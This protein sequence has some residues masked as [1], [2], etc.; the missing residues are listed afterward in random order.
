MTAA[1]NALGLEYQPLAPPQLDDPFPL[2]A[3][4][5]RE[6]PVTFAPGFHLWLVSRYQDVMTVLKDTRRF[7]SRDILRPP[8]DLPKELVELLTASGY[9][10]DY[11]LL[12]DDP[13]AH[14]RIRALV[15]KAFSPP[16]VS[17][18]EP[19]I[20]AIARGHLDAL[21]RNGTRADLISNLAWALPMDVITELLGVPHADRNQIREWTE[22]EKLIFVPQIPPDALRRAVEGVAAFRR[23]LRALVE[24]RQKN[25]REDILSTLISAR[26]DGENPL[27]TLEL[28][29]LASVLV[30]AGNETTTNLIGT[31]LLHL[32]RKPAL[33]E[34]LRANPAAIPNTIEEALRF[35]AP[36]VGMMRTATEPVQLGGA[37]IP[38]GARLLLLFASANRDETV[39]TDAERFD[40]HR[41]NASRHLG[42]G[43][44]THYCVGAPLA[45]L[46]ARV[47][48]GLLIEHLPNPRLAA[49]ETISYLPNLIHRGPGRLMVEWDAP[50]AL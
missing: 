4:L 7:S 13:P 22:H 15:G 28:M 30:F 34:E 18:M 17:A 20:R 46:E 38:A 36:V 29:N 11:P 5:R 14:T 41:A 47:A 26:I 31:T 2:Y 23:Y 32:L 9:S 39:F 10:A 27:T 49:G 45:R 50:P 48:L 40:L 33:W 6:A 42:F 3:R 19:R 24:D 35:D 43:H 12:G 44:G 8:V 25:P 1:A 16:N 37:N 21:L